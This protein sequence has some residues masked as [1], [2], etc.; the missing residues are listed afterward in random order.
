MKKAYHHGNLKEELV[1]AGIR[2][3]S[4]DGV[5]GLSLREVAG[6][7]GVSHAALYRHFKNKEDLLAS[8]AEDG[9]LSLVA[10][11]DAYQTRAGSN[12]KKQYLEAGRA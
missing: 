1:S 10:R 5:D 7:A 12:L 11:V 4:K 3:I 2:I 6:L 8:I 9:F